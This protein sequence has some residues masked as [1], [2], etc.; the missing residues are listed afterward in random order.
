M[1]LAF[2]PASAYLHDPHI[3]FTIAVD[4]A[5]LYRDSL[6]SPPPLAGLDR[7]DMVRIIKVGR[8]SSWIDYLVQDPPWGNIP[9]DRN[10]NPELRGEIPFAPAQG[11]QYL[12]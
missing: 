10:F 6:L 4:T 7:G 1:T 11:P 8:E 9:L 12:E 5:C 2:A 3:P